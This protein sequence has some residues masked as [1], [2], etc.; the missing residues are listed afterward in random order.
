MLITMQH[1]MGMEDSAHRP[2]K[3]DAESDSDSNAK[4]CDNCCKAMS[5]C[6]RRTTCFDMVSCALR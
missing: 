1:G 6:M 2:R 3:K 4:L 5:R